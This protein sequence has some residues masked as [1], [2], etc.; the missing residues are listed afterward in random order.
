MGMDKE[1]V[2]YTHDKILYPAIKKETNLCSLM[3]ESQYD[4][5]T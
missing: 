5:A 1:N 2:M 4:Y 3:D